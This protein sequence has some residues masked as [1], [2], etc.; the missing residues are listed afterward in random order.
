MARQTSVLNKLPLLA[1]IAVGAGVVLLVGVAYFVVFYGDI[2]SSIKAAKSQEQQLRTDLADAR[3]NEFAYQKDLAELTDRQQRQRELNKV[4]PVDTEYPSFLSAVQSVANVSGIGLTSWTPQPEVN[5]QFYARV[6][7]KVT[8]VGR[9]HQVAKFFYGVGQL[10]RIINMENIS[11]TEP[12]VQGDDVVVK[13]E[14]LAT[15]F[16]SVEDAKSTSTDKRG[17]AMGAPQ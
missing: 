12:K 4:L 14:A 1:R 7:M 9:Y 2:E 15:A 8:L 13:T 16:R 5:E 3:K 10:D 11:L 6:P 17:S